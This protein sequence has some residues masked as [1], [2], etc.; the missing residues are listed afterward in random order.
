MFFLDVHFRRFQHREKLIESLIHA[1]HVIV[2]NYNMQG[3]NKTLNELFAMLKSAKVDIK[4]EHQVLMV[5][6]TTSFKKAKAKK[7]HFKKSGKSAAARGSK[8]VVAPV[9]PKDGPK[10]DTVFLLQGRR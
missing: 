7:G 5:N 2:L 9:K 8:R 1:L 3:M 10:P 4:K 6:K